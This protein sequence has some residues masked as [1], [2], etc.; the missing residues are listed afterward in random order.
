MPAIQAITAMM[1]SALIQAILSDRNLNIASLQT[2][3]GAKSLRTDART[4]AAQGSFAVVGAH[5]KFGKRFDE[6]GMGTHGG[7]A[8]IIFHPRAQGKMGIFQVELDKR[9]GMLRHK[10]NRHDG[11]AL[12]VRSRAPDFAIG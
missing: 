9:F 10:G 12:A 7:H 2:G 5:D 3:A 8:Q 1:W 11:N 4:S 6:F